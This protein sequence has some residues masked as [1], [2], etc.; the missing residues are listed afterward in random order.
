MSYVDE[1]IERVIKENPNEPEFWDKLTNYKDLDRKGFLDK[2]KR[3]LSL[4]NAIDSEEKNDQRNK[5]DKI[6]SK[7]D[8]LDKIVDTYAFTSDN[9]IK[10]I[11]ILLRIRAKTPVIL[12]GET[13][14]GKTSLIKMIS[15]L[16]DNYMI[17]FDIHAGITDKEIIEM[18]EENGLLEG[19]ENNLKK[20]AQKEYEKMK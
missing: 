20:K 7:L 11:L 10:M 17:T 9:Y 3:A 13:G 6:M 12:M 2:I 4:H 16:K 14:C 8:T 19:F 15:K 5:I 18:L 1:V